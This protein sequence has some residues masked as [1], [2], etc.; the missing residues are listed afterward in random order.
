MYT[1]IKV[2]IRK[3]VC[4]MQIIA[5]KKSINSVCIGDTIQVIS[6]KESSI[7]DIK[8]FCQKTGNT[9]SISRSSTNFHFFLTRKY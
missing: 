8:Y 3:L 9:F 1:K 7:K 5:I 4:P 2:D 6:D